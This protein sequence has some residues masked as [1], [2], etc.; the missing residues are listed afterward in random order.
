MDRDVDYIAEEHTGGDGRRTS[1]LRTA[2]HTDRLYLDSGL[3]DPMQ[4]YPN[5]ST[6]SPPATAGN[7]ASPVPV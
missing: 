7:S 3:T 5:W 4:A 6:T 2:R 1:I